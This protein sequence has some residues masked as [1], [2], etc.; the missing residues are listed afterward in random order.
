M[1]KDQFIKRWIASS[2]SWSSYFASRYPSNLVITIDSDT[3]FTV[4]HTNN[5][6]QDYSLIRYELS[7]DGINFTE[8]TT[9]VAGTASKAI[10]GLTAGVVYYVRLRY[11]KGT[12]YSAYSET[13]SAVISTLLTGLKAYYKLEDV[14]DSFNGYHLTNNNAV[15]FVAG[16]LGNAANLGTSN[17]N[18]SLSVNTVF[19]MTYSTLKSVDG[20][21]KIN[22]APGVGVVYALTGL[23]FNT[24]PGNYIR[25]LYTND[26]GNFVIHLNTGSKS[27]TEL[28]VGTWYYLC[29][30]WDHAGNHAR[31]YVNNVLKINDAIFTANYSA[32]TGQLTIGQVENVLFASEMVDSLGI[33]N[34]ILTDAERTE[35]L[36][37][38]VGITYP[39][40]TPPLIISY[41]AIQGTVPDSNIITYQID[42][43]FNGVIDWGDGTRNVLIS[44]AP[45]KQIWHTH[46]TPNTTYTIR[47]FGIADKFKHFSVNRQSAKISL[48]EVA[49][50]TALEYF[51]ASLARC[52]G[53]LNELVS[54]IKTAI[55]YHLDSASDAVINIGPD[56]IVGSID[57]LP[58]GM[59]GLLQLEYCFG[60]GEGT[61]SID[62]LPVGLTGLSIDQ[63]AAPTAF[64]GSISN[65]PAGL[66]GSVYIYGCLL[67]DGSINA[68]PAGINWLW[69]I[70]MPLITG[71]INNLSAGIT[72]LVLYNCGLLTGDIES[73]NTNIDT[74][75][76]NMCDVIYGGGAVPAWRNAKITIQNTWGGGINWSAAMTSDFLIAWALTAQIA[77]DGLVRACYIGYPRDASSDAAL[78]TLQAD[79]PKKTIT[80]T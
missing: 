79:P 20:W 64:I 15:T 74:I 11:S 61:G 24:N 7:T 10:T 69:L 14:N 5:G 29:A 60:T 26:A 63:G 2:S 34:K 57:D 33:W 28:V 23:M 75:E 62:N 49:K 77:D 9:A 47:I 27:S 55:F 54:T 18:K 13:V 70:N 17:T 80:T 35:R 38:G 41:Q 1:R 50:F 30:T 46:S 76:I 37:L 36:N 8:N 66:T 73:I 52:T 42:D 68:L 45:Y 25:I 72:S 56:H 21:F 3:Q 59:T 6:T 39:F 44:G 58:A 67:L 32:K 40:S 53:N 16:K 19:G 31:L 78:A 65:L 22:T 43:G 48:S 71:S 12:H 51:A 4:T